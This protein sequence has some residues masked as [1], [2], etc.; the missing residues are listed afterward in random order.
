MNGITVT[1]ALVDFFPVVLFFIAS[2]YLQRDLYNKMVK[3]AYALLSTGTIMVFIGG[4]FKVIWKILYALNICDYQVLNQG[5]FLIQ[6]PG[7]ILGFLGLIGM[8]SKYNKARKTQ[9][10][11]VVPVFTSNLPFIALQVIGCSGIQVCL[12]YFALKMKKKLAAI[13]FIV[14]FIFM[15]GMGYLSAKFDDSSNM[16]W[17][18]QLVN[19]VSQG[20]FL[21]AVI[22]LDKAG[23]GKKD[24]LGTIG[25]DA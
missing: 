12:A 15:L 5:F 8:I 14:S 4:L 23:L 6:A 11:G 10:L 18:A 24:A 2:I 1:M 19:T 25:I 7:F 22:I 16:H 20:S 17:L 9:M 21:G 3:G 13:L